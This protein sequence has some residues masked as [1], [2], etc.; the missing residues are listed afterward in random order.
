[1]PSCLEYSLQSPSPLVSPQPANSS[2]PSGLRGQPSR[3]WSPVMQPWDFLYKSQAP[4]LSNPLPPPPDTGPWSREP[5][6]CFLA[7]GTE[8]ML[9]DYLWKEEKEG[10]TEGG[11]RTDRRTDPVS[12]VSLPLSSPTVLPPS[13]PSFKASFDVLSPSFC[14]SKVEEPLTPRGE[15]GCQR[16][17]SSSSQPAG[18]SRPLFLLPPR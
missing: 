9:K 14:G 17:S 15:T 16:P 4:T 11:R 1:M 12:L 10:G 3:A 6:N 18:T 5:A 7:L 13:C 2:H 8:E